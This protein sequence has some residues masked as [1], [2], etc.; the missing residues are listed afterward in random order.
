MI[1]C[2]RHVGVTTE[3]WILKTQPVL[4]N[5]DEIKFVFRGITRRKEDYSDKIRDIEV[6]KKK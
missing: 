4:E 1:F 3:T 2:G 5:G 6:S